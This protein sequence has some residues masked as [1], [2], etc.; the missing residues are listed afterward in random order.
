MAQVTGKQ[1]SIVFISTSAA[2]SLGMSVTDALDQSLWDLFELE[3][4][5]PCQ[6]WACNGRGSPQMG[7]LSW[8]AAW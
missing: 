5:P 1:A 2:R 7:P 8:T 6:R 3:G 4:E